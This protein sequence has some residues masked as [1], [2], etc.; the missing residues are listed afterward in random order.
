MFSLVGRKDPA[1]SYTISVSEALLFKLF[2]ISGCLL[3]LLF[4]PAHATEISPTYLFDSDP[5]TN[6]SGPIDAAIQFGFYAA[7]LILVQRCDIQRHR[8]RRQWENRIGVGVLNY[9]SRYRLS[10]EMRTAAEAEA[11]KQLDVILQRGK[12][13]LDMCKNADAMFTKALT[14]NMEPPI[15]TLASSDA[16]MENE[17]LVDQLK[18]GFSGSVRLRKKILSFNVDHFTRTDHHNFEAVIH[19]KGSGAAN[20]VKGH[21]SG[22]EQLLWKET[23]SLG[24]KRSREYVYVLNRRSPTEMAGSWGDRSRGGFVE[25]TLPASEPEW[26][27]SP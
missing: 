4:V 12:I 15:G 2:I 17:R 3:S 16:E 23:A 21:V 19:W 7:N 25:I 27:A 24:G 13:P 10:G 8:P 26:G 14:T 20:V 18:D 11:R 9:G 6:R 1:C 5:S 22:Y